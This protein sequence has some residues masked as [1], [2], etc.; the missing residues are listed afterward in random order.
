MTPKMWWAHTEEGR[1]IPTGCTDLQEAMHYFKTL[2]ATTWD[3]VVKEWL[4]L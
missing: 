3:N 2:C 1:L 4:F